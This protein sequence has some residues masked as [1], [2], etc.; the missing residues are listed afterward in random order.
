MGFLV[1]HYSAYHIPYPFPQLLTPYITQSGI[2][3][4]TKKLTLVHYC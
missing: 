3:A 1:S 2:C 4:K